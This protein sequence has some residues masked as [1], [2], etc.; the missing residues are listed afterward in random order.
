MTFF[1]EFLPRQILSAFSRKA[2]ACRT[3]N[4]W[5]SAGTAFK[6]KREEDRLRM[7]RKSHEKTDQMRN[8]GIPCGR[9]IEG[10][11]KRRSSGE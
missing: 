3:E 1:T 5:F 7:E 9:E 10:A 4:I 6:I 8:D 11:E 2:A